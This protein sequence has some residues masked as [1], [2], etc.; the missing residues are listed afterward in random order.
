MRR[1]R[2]FSLLGVRKRKRK[3]LSVGKVK[4]SE[5]SPRLKHK[6]NAS[7]VI[8]Q[9]GRLNEKN[10]SFVNIEKDSFVSGT[11]HDNFAEDA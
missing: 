8:Q 4:H 5:N 10:K 7:K 9:H 2:C 3:E 11:G 1:N 6:K